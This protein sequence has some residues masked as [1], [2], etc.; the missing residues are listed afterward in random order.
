M[1]SRAVTVLFA[2]AAPIVSAATTDLLWQIG[3]LSGTA[4]EYDPMEVAVG[5]SIRFHWTGEHNL[6]QLPTKADY[7]DCAWQD[8]TQI[9]GY[10][11]PGEHTVTFDQEGTFYFI[12]G[13]TGHCRAGQ[14]I[15]VCVGDGGCEEES[16]DPCFPSS[17]SVTLADGTVAR[18]DSLKEGDSI[19]SATD[20]GALSTDTVS[21]LSVAKPG[22]SATFLTLSTAANATLTLTPEHHLP[23]GAECCSTLKKAKDVSVG[24]TMWAVKDGKAVATTVTTV[25]KA[26]S[27]GLHS[28]VLTHGGFPIVD[29]V[30]TAFDSIE[31]VALAKHGLAPLL[32]AC[33]ATKTCDEF[34][35]MFLAGDR[36]YVEALRRRRL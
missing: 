3:G 19:V 9:A 15:K 16:D 27:N 5:D 24:E 23:V 33:K 32:A 28:P 2:T 30:V 13:Y 14:K 1:P 29:G 22:S 18:I 6:E 8:A 12:C 10:S 36:K 20:S 17:A 26:H 25:S 4:D 11:D 21:L 34:K 35:E 7:E 31:K